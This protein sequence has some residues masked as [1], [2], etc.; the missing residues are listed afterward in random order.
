MRS[1]APVLELKL[2]AAAWEP[3]FPVHVPLSLRLEPGDC[4]F[5][6]VTDGIE[7]GR[8]ADLCSGLV[9]LRSGEVQ[10]LNRDW[11]GLPGVYADALRGR[12]GRFFGSGGWLPFLDVESNILL[13]ALHHTRRS[14]EDLRSEAL[15]LAHEFGLPGLPLDRPSDLSPADLDRAALIRTFLGEPLLVLIEDRGDTPLSRSS[16]V[17]NRIAVACD[18][19]AAIAWLVRQHS[20]SLQVPLPASQHFRLSHEGLALARTAA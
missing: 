3:G 4:V 10:F 7:P 17:L 20:A 2:A 5:I 18:R 19:G 6:E 1:G 8:F 9:R 11:Q 16:A 12:I 13:Q 14:R 15:A